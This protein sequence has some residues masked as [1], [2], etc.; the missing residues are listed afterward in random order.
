MRD[1]FK[2]KEIE[3]TAPKQPYLRKTEHDSFTYTDVYR[4]QWKTSRQTNPL[5]PTYI[6]RENGEG[7]RAG[8]GEV[9]QNYGHIRGSKPPT[10]PAE[11]Q[12]PKRYLNT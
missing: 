9:S 1:V 4:N 12:D 5:D 10:L 7:F 11:K 6:H 3:G 8:S 2:V